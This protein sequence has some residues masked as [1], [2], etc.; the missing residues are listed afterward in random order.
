MAKAPGARSSPA[1]VRPSSGPWY[2]P[3]ATIATTTAPTT[4]TGARSAGTGRYDRAATTLVTRWPA[5]MTPNRATATPSQP[6]DV[7]QPEVVVPEPSTTAIMMIVAAT[8]L[9]TKSAYP[10]SQPQARPVTA[11]HAP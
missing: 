8:P 5:Y 7:S 6:D 1:T 9:T 3:I 2:T 11:D 4:A 10:N